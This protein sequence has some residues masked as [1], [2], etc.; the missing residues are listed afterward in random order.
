MVRTRFP[1]IID[2]NSE[3]KFNMVMS[4]HLFTRFLV[5]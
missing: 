2:I 5:A 1:N 3:K 4:L